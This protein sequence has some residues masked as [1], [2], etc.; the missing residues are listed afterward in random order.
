MVR[1]VEQH[2]LKYLPSADRPWLRLSG[3]SPRATP[4]ARFVSSA[5]GMSLPRLVRLTV[6]S[7]PATRSTRANG[8][9]APGHRGRAVA[10][11]RHLPALHDALPAYEIGSILGHG[12]FGM[13][14]AARHIA[15]GRDVA[16]KHLWP[17]L[18]QD[19]DARTRFAGEARV[20]AA[21]D[22]PNVVRVY[23]YVEADIYALVIERMRGGTLGDRLVAG[24]I[25]FSNACKIALALLRGLEHAHRNGVLHRDIKPQNLLFDDRGALKIADFGLATVIGP[26]G[27]LATTTARQ[28]GTPAY[29]APEQLSPSL[30]RVSP[31]TDVWAAGAVLY[32]ML[33]GQRPSADADNDP[34]MLWRRVEQDAAPV[35]DVDP[36]VPRELSDVVSRALARLP[37]QRF[38][39]AA[40][41]AGALEAATTA[42]SSAASCSTC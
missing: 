33:A 35:S 20:M 7:G 29:M 9:L 10:S 8:S 31:A 25:S 40:E 41:F 11:A 26:S 17:E 23:D 42:V 18:I 15:L 27:A 1:S 22:H 24:S 2:D 19:N 6:A 30:G 34:V 38:P 13:V 32:E 5:P 12:A 37:A 39:A 3:T 21:L 14:Y 28:P 16:I 4:R 36:E